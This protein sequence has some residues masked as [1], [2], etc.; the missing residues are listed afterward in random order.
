M[1]NELISVIVPIYNVENYLDKCIQSICAQTYQDLEIILV[2]DGSTDSSG[3]ICDTYV[4]KDPRVRVIH[5]QNGGLSDARNAGIEVAVGKWFSFI[6]SDDFIANDTIEKL[7]LAAVSNNC[8]ISV[9]NMVRIFEDGETQDFY[10]PVNEVTILKDSQRFETLNQPSV[11]NKLFHA[12]LFDGVRFPKGKFYE[13]TFVYHVLAYRAKNIALTGHNGYYYLSRRGSILGQPRYSDRY[14]DSVEAVYHRVSFLLAH[15]VPKYAEDACLSL[16]AFVS[17]AYRNIPKTAQNEENFR[18]MQG[19]YK[20]AY[21]H[22]M[23]RKDVSV[24]QKLRLV[25]LRYFPRLHN[26]I[27]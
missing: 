14:F 8:Q 15:Q 3:A 12:D 1:T 24:K 5:K 17:T 22:L 25:L 23:Q 9:C 13:D 10:N 20:V 2:D 26:R 18:Q 6:D 11:C 7:Y 19:W 21:Q 16:Y 4:P 27:Y